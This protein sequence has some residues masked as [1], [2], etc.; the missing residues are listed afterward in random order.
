VIAGHRDTFFRPLRN[1]QV[2]DDVFLD[3]RQGRFQYRVTSLRVVQPH[4]LSVLNRTDDTVLTLVTCYPFWV[5]GDAPDRFVVRAVA[6]SKAALPAFPPAAPVP[7]ES[8]GAP[9]AA[10]PAEAESLTPNTAVVPDDET[11]VRQALERFR[12]TYNARSISH[13]DAPDGLLRFG[14]CEVTV[15]ADRATAACDVAALTG[16]LQLWT[17]AFERAAGKWAIRSIAV[18]EAA[19]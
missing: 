11:L 2:G 15:A 4:D 19:R 5:L 18:E 8:T 7:G 17:V 16:D 13:N 9:P 1:I 6:V 3:T 14:T 12:R 10:P